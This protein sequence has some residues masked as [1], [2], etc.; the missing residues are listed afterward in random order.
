M[1]HNNRVST[2]NALQTSD[3]WSKTIG[4]DPYAN[5]QSE[6]AAAAESNAER[7]LDS[8]ADAENRSKGSHEATEAM[9]PVSRKR[10][11]SC[12]DG[13]ID[14]SAMKR[15]STR[16]INST[17]VENRNEGRHEATEAMSPVSRKRNTSCADGDID[18]SAMKRRSTR[19]INSSTPVT[20]TAPAPA[21][22]VTEKMKS[23]N[24]EDSGG[25]RSKNQ[26]MP[27]TETSTQRFKALP[28]PGWKHT[29]T[30]EYGRNASHWVSPVRNIAFRSRPLAC[31]FEQLRL[32]FDNDEVQA[33]EEFRRIKQ[34]SDTYV[35]NPSQ[36]DM[37]PIKTTQSRKPPPGPGWKYKR[38]V[39]SD[40]IHRWHWISPTRN[41]EFRRWAAADDFEKL[42]HE[43]G[44][45]GCA[46][47]EYR[48]RKAGSDTCVISPRKYDVDPI[49]KNS[50]SDD[51]SNYAEEI[52]TA[53]KPPP[54]PGWKHKFVVE[55]AGGQRQCHW[56]SPVRNIEFRRWPQAC[57]FEKLRLKFGNEVQAWEEYRKMKVGF[58]TRVIS[59]SKYDTG[60]VEEKSTTETV[61]TPNGTSTTAPG[62]GWK[63]KLVSN[64]DDSQNRGHWM[65]PTGNI[66]FKRREAACEFEVLRQTFGN[67][68]Q[69]W[70]EYGEVQ[71]NREAVVL[72]GQYDDARIGASPKSNGG[73]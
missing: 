63:Y 7:L 60:G 36:Y 59:A 62:P 54:G 67:E 52:L 39:E 55:V 16:L 3:I 66:E 20:A 70:H 26:R 68:E 15:R 51:D 31:E 38:V 4:H 23:K 1:P 37:K 33:W 18:H 2:S 34:G 30:S 42:R 45:E 29:Q 47:E 19:L 50:P 64:A 71:A 72:P 65:S 25:A 46:W 13:D 17:D 6:D 21:K 73:A 27:S 24:E 61:A 53:K 48:R 28:G 32:T 49:E 8:S 14:H 44:N 22:K 11:T 41:I 12:A 56:L 57:E 10:N 40:E 58:R 5:K 43:F 35:I 69:A 9:S